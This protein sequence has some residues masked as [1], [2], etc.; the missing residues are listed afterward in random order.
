MLCKFA[1][2][3]GMCPMRMYTT[4]NSHMRVHSRLHAC[5][6]SPHGRGPGTHVYRVHNTNVDATTNQDTAK[7]P[8]SDPEEL[9][10]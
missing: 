1:S 8:A 5:A 9:G 4:R 2:Q 10:W 6:E 7:V 3:T